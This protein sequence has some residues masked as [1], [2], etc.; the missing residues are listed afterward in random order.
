MNV[1]EELVASYLQHIRGC[2]F[3]QKNLYTRDVQ[4]EIDVVGINLKDKSIYVCEVAIH[5]QTG[6]RYTKNKRPNN[7]GKLTEKFSRDIEYANKYFQEYKRHFM[8]WSPIVKGSKDGSKYNQIND[9]KEVSS[10]INGQYDVN[11]EFIVNERFLS[12]IKELRAYAASKT[13]EIKCPVLRLLQLEE[14]L[15]RHVKRQG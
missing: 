3:T 2:D 10:I 6:L 14:A 4:G 9:L 12:C 5:L 15:A 11:I 1:G 8:L 13:E 7:V